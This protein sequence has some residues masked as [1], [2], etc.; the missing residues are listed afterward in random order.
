VVRVAGT[1]IVN[2]DN[3]HIVAVDRILAVTAPLPHRTRQ[4]SILDGSS[5]LLSRIAH[6]GGSA[7]MP[8]P[9]DMVL[10]PCEH[11]PIGEI[12]AMRG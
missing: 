10:D 6:S 3:F 5:N 9:V 1:A 4:W 2:Q 12:V 11:Q 7:L 8:R